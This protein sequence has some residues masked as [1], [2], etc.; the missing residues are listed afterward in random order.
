MR[1]RPSCDV[2]PPP[3]YFQLYCWLGEGDS[4]RNLKKINIPIF[5]GVGG[6]DLMV[7]S[8]YFFA[9][10]SKKI[11]PSLRQKNRIYAF[12]IYLPPCHKS[13]VGTR[14]CPEFRLMLFPVP[15]EPII[16]DQTLHRISGYRK[17]L[18]TNPVNFSGSGW[19][20]FTWFNNTAF[21]RISDNRDYSAPSPVNF[22]V[23]GPTL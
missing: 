5:Q 14:V 9:S 16:L 11:C 1:L 8:E 18:A 3:P 13:N 17:Y 12:E 21:H 22:D 20:N 19:T 4:M 7:Y 2:D 6:I 23:S 15:V 10:Q